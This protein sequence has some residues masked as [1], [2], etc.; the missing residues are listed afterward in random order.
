MKIS[1]IFLTNDRP[2]DRFPGAVLQHLQWCARQFHKSMLACKDQISRELENFG[3]SAALLTPM[4]SCRTGEMENLVIC[5]IWGGKGSAFEQELTDANNIDDGSRATI[6]NI[7]SHHQDHML[8]RSEEEVV[9]LAR[10]VVWS[11]DT[12]FG[13]GS[14]RAR[15][16]MTECIETT[17]VGSW[18]PIWNI[19]N[20]RTVWVAIP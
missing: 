3:R 1:I 20:Q 15:E 11:L 9:L 16:D 18:H 4:A 14:C 19:D 5:C 17:L 10:N 2:W 13:T 6:L 12:D 8:D 7:L